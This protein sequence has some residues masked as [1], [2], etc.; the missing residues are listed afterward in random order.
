MAL[1]EII[2]DAQGVPTGEYK[3]VAGGTL[4]ADSPIGT[5]LPY[6]GATAPV[7]WLLCQGQAVSR[8]T[9]AELFT[10][11]GTA[12]GAGDGSTTF[13]IPDMR[14]SVPKG[15]GETG[16]T[17]GAHVKSGGLAVG[18]FF[19]DRIQN[20]TLRTAETYTNAWSDGYMVRG[21]S[22]DIQFRNLT[23]DD[24]SNRDLSGNARTGVTTEVKSVG[25]NYIIK[26]KMVAMPSDFMSNVEEAVN[27]KLVDPTVERLY[28]GKI[29][30]SLTDYTLS[31]D[32]TQYRELLFVT[33]GG[34]DASVG[35]ASE[36][37]DTIPVKAFIHL[38]TD[39]SN[40]MLML[41]RQG[42]A[43]STWW[44]R[45]KYKDST[46]I[47]MYTGANWTSDYLYIYGIR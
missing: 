38:C 4:W 19:D 1:K 8:I 39:I 13:N 29:T 33:Q 20:I 17:V 24:Q 30:T 2:K 14:E 3:S 11:I 12:F 34:S 44:V 40:F 9:Y 27:E 23:Y 22:R 26:A 16:Q 18:E 7:G 6:G 5:I 31:K 28:V 43:S 47:S 25:V 41:T 15:A 45:A 42:A 10:A 36:F 32:M 35:N 21:N 37:V 46:H